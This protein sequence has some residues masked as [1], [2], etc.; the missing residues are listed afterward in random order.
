MYIQ[1]YIYIY[2]YIC[3]YIYIYTYICILYRYKYI[4]ISIC[5][6][7]YL[8]IYLSM[9]PGKDEARAC[10]YIRS[11]FIHWAI[12]RTLMRTEYYLFVHHTTSILAKLCTWCFEHSLVTSSV[13]AL[14]SLTPS[15]TDESWGGRNT[16]MW[17]YIYYR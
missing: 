15:H 2:I 16:C 5:V 17:I 13:R 8:P 3:T 14:Y 4:R 7:I 6:S 1:I 12:G 10:G 11:E 9:S